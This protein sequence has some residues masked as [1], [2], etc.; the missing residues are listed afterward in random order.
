MSSI[1]EHKKV[2]RTNHCNGVE[3][4]EETGPGVSGDATGILR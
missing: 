1:D 2:L 4:I 3:Q